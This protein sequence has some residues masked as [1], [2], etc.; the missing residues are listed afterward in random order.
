MSIINRMIQKYK[1]NGKKPASMETEDIS[2]HMPFPC[3]PN[4]I[5]LHFTITSIMYEH[6]ITSPHTTKAVRKRLAQQLHDT[7]KNPSSYRH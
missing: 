3:K 4:L 1:E 2:Q 5:L 7:R 6:Y